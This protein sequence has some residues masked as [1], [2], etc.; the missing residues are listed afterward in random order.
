MSL[1]I[2]SLSQRASPAVLTAIQ[3]AST[4]TGVD[5]KYLMEKAATESS[6][7]PD[8][9]AKTSTARGLYQFIESTWLE[10]VDKHGAEHG[11]EQAANAIQRDKRGRPVV[12]NA[13]SRREILALRNDPKIAA[14]MA[15]ELAKDNQTTLEHKLG[16]KVGNAELYMAHFLGAGGAAKFLSRLDNNPDS[17]AANIIPA[18]ARANRSVF[19]QSGRALSV[20][21]VFDRFAAKFDS[22]P[23]FLSPTLSPMTPAE[24]ADS[25]PA[26]VA[27]RMAPELSSPSLALSSGNNARLNSFSS[28]SQ[29]PEPTLPLTALKILASLSIPGE[30]D[31]PASGKNWFS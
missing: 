7:R 21:E 1:S 29:N 24:N 19:Y 20:G 26:M 4:Q 3:Q 5:F 9:Q 25:S 6:F 28:R 18:A 27:E 22:S 14:M 23:S 11:L 15:A 8:A 12:T 31:T 30:S 2:N 16:R 10:T 13:A 17:S